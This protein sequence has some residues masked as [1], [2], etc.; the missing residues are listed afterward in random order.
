MERTEL[1]IKFY[2]TI[3]VITILILGLF[4]LG[5]F[6][7]NTL[8]AIRAYVGG[9]GLWAKNQK[10]AC[11]ELLQYLHT[12][13]QAKYEVFLDN[14][15]IPL[16]DKEAR[17]ELEKNDPDYDIIIQGF[18]AG[19]NHPE[20]I[21]QMIVLYKRFRNNEQIGKAIEQWQL[22]D[23]LISKLIDLG[24]TIR[25]D[26][27]SGA[28]TPA[29]VRQ[30]ANMIESLQSQLN[31]AENQFSFH[32]SMAARWAV[33][34]L[35]NIMFVFS[36]VGSVICLGMLLF[37]GNIISKLK[38]YSEDL[39]ALS[40][41]ERATTS[42]LVQERNKLQAALAEIKTLHGI[43]PICSHCKKIRNDAGVWSQ[44]EQYIYEHSDA[45]FSHSVCPDCA[46]KYYPDVF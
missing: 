10:N 15:N 14:L 3:F 29:V 46:K 18:L 35:K 42:E 21:P 17:L 43:I 44:L 39:E 5:I 7:F 45:E 20:D 27:A 2:V 31:Q 16:G 12:R 38:K 13:D 28:L 8:A 34:L 26:I 41:S 24:E 22:G 23:L 36:V 11:Y 9:E 6:G 33:N 25:R 19:G 4:S 40:E 32:M 30:H 37:V 1:K